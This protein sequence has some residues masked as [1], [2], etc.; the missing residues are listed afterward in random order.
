MKHS[1]KTTAQLV[2]ILLTAFTGLQAQLKVELVYEPADVKIICDDL[3]NFLKAFKMIEDG[4]NLAETLQQEYL[5]KASPGLKNYMEDQGFELKDFV[6]RF[7]QYKKNYTTLPALPGQLASE[8]G[9]IRKALQSMKKIFPKPAFLPIYVIVGISGGL[10]A[11][12]SEFGIRL[13]FSRAATTD[14]LP[15]LKLTIIHELV[16][17]QQALAVGMEQYQAIYNGKRSLLAVSI[18]EGVAEF[19]TYLISGKYSK[20]DCYDFIKKHEKKIWENF[21]VEMHNR[22]FGDWLFS[23]PKDPEQ[24]RDLGY[25]MGAMIVEAYYENVKDKKK[26]IDEILKITNYPDFLKRS[27]YAEK[28][29]DY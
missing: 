12:P 4:A 21:K 19:M 24:P 11:E 10:H 3:H 13:A 6:E 25:I 16:H 29:Q 28:F 22:E 20:K 17:V 1:L 7:D 14:R 5:G 2:L 23:S 27:R 26:A 9:N 18:R 8:E 15:G